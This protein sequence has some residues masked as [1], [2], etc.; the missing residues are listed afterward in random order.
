V[1]SANESAPRACLHNT[2]CV[3]AALADFELMAAEDGGLS[4]AMDTP[5]RSL[6]LRTDA[7]ADDGQVLLGV[8]I[9]PASDEPLRPGLTFVGARFV[10]WV[11]LA[12]TW[13]AAGQAFELCYPT[14]VV[15]RGVIT[16]IAPMD[17]A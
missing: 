11:D 15:G 16:S 17:T 10:F 1:S 14:R 4:S 8:V 3:I 13:L 9:S 5:C 2:G 7:G 6:L 12:A